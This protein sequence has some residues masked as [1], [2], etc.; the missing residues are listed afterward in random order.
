[1]TPLGFGTDGLRGVANSELTPEIVMSLG[2]A[3]AKV[4]GRSQPYLLGRDTRRSG[5]M[6]ACALVAGLTAEGAEV[7]DLG[8]CPTPAVAY[9]A[10]L[11]SAAGL[12]ISASHNPFQDNGVK[13]F[14][15]GGLKL[16]VA[17]ETEIELELSKL[18]AEVPSQASGLVGD[19]VGALEDG[20]VLL[21]AYE[22][23][24]CASLE[25]RSLDGLFVVLDCANGAVSDLAPRVL[26]RLGAHVEVT[27]ASP[28]GTNINAGCGAL[29]PEGL[30][31]GVLERKADLGLAFDGDADRLIAVD[32][33]GHVLDGDYLLALFASDLDERSLLSGR[34]VAITV[35]SNLGLRRA[36]ASAGIRIVETPVGDRHLLDAIA[37]GDL[38]LGGEQSGHIIFPRLASTGDGLLTGVLLADLVLRNGRALSELSTKAMVRFPQRLVNFR[39]SRRGELSNALAVWE[40]VAAVE[41][42][43]GERG[44]VLVRESGTEPLVRVMVEAETDDLVETAL[45]TLLSCLEEALGTS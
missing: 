17:R 12:V 28:D 39:T 24:I 8:V 29:H 42:W 35:M 14:A 45:A 36:L 25:G 1:M 19:G 31:A 3:T 32:H 23:H 9:L 26:R 34:G 2:R 44:R 37:E 20:R 41:T 6:L 10:S 15:T 27:S 38:C 5:A 13:V 43:L 21:G 22:D 40:E 16:P 18:V 33:E 4:L 11:I 30:A 7:Q